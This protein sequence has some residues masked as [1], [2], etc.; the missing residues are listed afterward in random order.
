[1]NI[2]SAIMEGA[3]ILKNNFIS[4]AY[5]DSEILM[6]KAI[7]YGVK[8]GRQAV[9][10]GRIKQQKIAMASSPEKNINN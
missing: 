8:A 10:A 6:A 9:L 3:K 1:M 5:L 4:T 7:N 2:N